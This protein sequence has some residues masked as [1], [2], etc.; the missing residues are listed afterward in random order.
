MN[1][2]PDRDAVRPV[3]DTSGRKKRTPGPKP[4]RPPANR[5]NWGAELSSLPDTDRSR[6]GRHPSRP[7]RRRELSTDRTAS[8]VSRRSR[9]PEVRTQAHYPRPPKPSRASGRTPAEPARPGPYPVGFLH[10][11][12]RVPSPCDATAASP[13]CRY[14]SATPREVRAAPRRRAC[15]RAGPRRGDPA[16]VGPIHASDRPSL[17]CSADRRR[18]YEKPPR[19]AADKP[20]PLQVSLKPCPRSGEGANE[21]LTFVKATARRL[22]L[23]QFRAGC[24]ENCV[25]GVPHHPGWARRNR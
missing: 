9:H 10:P 14:P 19:T 4:G 7:K 2:Q 23:D 21:G 11:A 22:D 1:S 16:D 5:L 3:P 24:S 13:V 15:T 20:K 12:A 18:P 17:A 25:A 8:P 6:K